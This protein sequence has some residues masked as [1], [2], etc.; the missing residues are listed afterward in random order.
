MTYF[1]DKMAENCK[2][3]TDK[4]AVLRFIDYR[5]VHQTTF[6]SSFFS[7]NESNAKFF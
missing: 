7:K 5:T 4:M 3:S 6:N 2:I 1:A